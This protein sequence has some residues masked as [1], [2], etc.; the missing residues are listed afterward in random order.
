MLPVATIGRNRIACLRCKLR[1]PVGNGPCA[2]TADGVDIID[3]AEAGYCAMP[4]RPRYG[5]GRKP[6]GWDERP[7]A[8]AVVPAVPWGPAAWKLLHTE[9]IGKDSEWFAQWM[10]RVPCGE[11]RQKTR[12]ILTAQPM[13]FPITPLVTWQLHDAINAAIGKPRLTYAEAAAAHGWHV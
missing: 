9:G 1:G 12:A 6:Q 13:Q 8:G 3:H 4:R 2:C 7:K 10:R 11:C 5:D